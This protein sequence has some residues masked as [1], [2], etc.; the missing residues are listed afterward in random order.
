MMKEEDINMNNT[1]NQSIKFKEKSF[2]ITGEFLTL[3]KD[4]DKSLT[5]NIVSKMIETKGGIIKKS[6]L[7]SLDYLVIGE[8]GS[9]R[10]TKGTKGKKYTKAEEQQNTNII[11]ETELLKAL[12][13]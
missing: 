12:K 5:R 8:A 13:Y 10:Y 6:V 7:K 9:D 11:S 1:S 4:S 2:C 3:Q